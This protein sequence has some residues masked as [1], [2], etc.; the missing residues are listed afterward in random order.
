MGKRLTGDYPYIE[1]DVVYAVQEYACSIA[2]VLGRRTRLAFLN[3]QAAD[4]C[5]SKV[6]DIMAKEL[7]WSRA[8]KEVSLS[9]MW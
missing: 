4:Q 8:K 9:G 5:V 1:A 2:D 6:A 7:N 3:V